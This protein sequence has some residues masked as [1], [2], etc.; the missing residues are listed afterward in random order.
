MRRF[1]VATILGLTLATPAFAA[2]ADAPLNPLAAASTA[3]IATA[4][5]AA[6]TAKADADT[7]AYQRFSYRRPS[8]LPA[9]YMTSAAL[10]GY[11]AF[12][13]MKALKNGARE[14]NP[15]MQAVVQRPAVFIAMKAGV[16]TASIMAAE[17]LWK[18]NHRL[19][20]IGL[21]VA[22]NVMMGAVAAHNSRVLS[23]LK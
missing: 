23:S 11:D 9:M 8:L 12:S 18:G 20:A 2:D 14:A 4:T 1:V 7:D 3:A 17:Q 13:T 15:F 21:M 22:S 6:P 5:N 16:T 19:G 10:Q